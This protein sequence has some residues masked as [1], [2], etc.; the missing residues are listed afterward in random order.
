MLCSIFELLTQDLLGVFPRMF[1]LLLQ[2]KHSRLEFID[3]F[4]G[5][6]SLHLHS[7]PGTIR[8]EPNCRMRSIFSDS[9]DMKRRKIYPRE[10][11]QQILLS[12]SF[13][14]CLTSLIQ[15][16]QTNNAK[17]SDNRYAIIGLG[18]AQEF[19]SKFKFCI[20]TFLPKIA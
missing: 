6:C 20:Y 12:F 4:S 7:L 5:K 13:L 16:G 11:T 15:I 14:D 17:Y 10:N 8:F 3:F 18:R 19:V 1:F 9:I 2:Q